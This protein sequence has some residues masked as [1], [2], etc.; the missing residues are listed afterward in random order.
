MVL[1]TH[2]IKLMAIRF[3]LSLVATINIYFMFSTAITSNVNSSIIITIFSA[4]ALITSLI[5]YLVLNEKVS[6]RH[7][8][9][10]IFL[11]ISVVLIANS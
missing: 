5:F 8:M 3:I 10:M 6:M 1:D 4:T 9:G 2:L 11:I 7:Y